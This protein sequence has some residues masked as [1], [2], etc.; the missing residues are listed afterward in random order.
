MTPEQLKNLAESLHM[1]LLPTP[2]IYHGCK[3]VYFYH[4]R[5]RD[6]DWGI[7]LR[8]DKDDNIGGQVLKDW[9]NPN[10]PPKWVR[11]MTKYINERGIKI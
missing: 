5:G 2:E 11:R 6:R 8:I 7:E 1:K 9:S 3:V 10:K 4:R